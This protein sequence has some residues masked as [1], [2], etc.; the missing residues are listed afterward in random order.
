MAKTIFTIIVNDFSIFLVYCSLGCAVGHLTPFN[1]SFN[2]HIYELHSEYVFC[3]SSS[4]SHVAFGAIV[5]VG[6]SSSDVV[7][8]IIKHECS[9]LV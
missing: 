2:R 3:W 7:H 4:F 1:Q 5:T 9:R 6:S 8:G